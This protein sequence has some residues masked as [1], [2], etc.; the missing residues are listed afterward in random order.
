MFWKYANPHRFLGLSAVLLPW[1]AG[2]T[3]VLVTAGVYL[4]LFVSPPDYQQSETVRIMYVHVPAAW[5]GLFCYSIMAAASA[6]VLVWKHPLAAMVA[7]CTA[8]IGASFTFLA[9]LTGSL[10]GKPMWGTWWVWD[11]RLT[12]VLVLL[13]LYLGY[14]ALH[15]AFDDPQRGS[16]AASVLALVGFVN[17]PIIKF[18]VDWWNTLHQPSS[19]VTADGPAIH[20]SML[21]PLLVMASAYTAYYVWVLLLRVRGEIIAAKIRTLQMRQASG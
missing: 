6:A 7:K 19:M 20:A 18:S 8:P 13:F 11:A 16:K 9:L 15:N 12:S 17:V 3:L 14:I 4:A 5:M 10:W 1:T 2:A 21:A